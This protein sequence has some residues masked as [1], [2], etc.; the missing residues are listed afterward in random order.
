MA[1][2]RNGFTH[3]PNIYQITSYVLTLVVFVV[4]IVCVVPVAAAME[5]AA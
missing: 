1:V 5:D 4:I 2:N 3:P